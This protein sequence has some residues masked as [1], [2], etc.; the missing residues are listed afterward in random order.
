[1][2]EFR[3]TGIG[4]R[5]GQQQA[6]T[7][8]VPSQA[9]TFPQPGEVVVPARKA[10]RYAANCVTCGGRVQA[11]EGYLAGQKGAWAAEH[12]VCPTSESLAAVEEPTEPVVAPVVQTVVNGS[13]VFDGTYTLETLT[14]HRTFRLRTQARGEDFM[15]GKQIIEYLSGADNDADYTRFGHVAN[16]EVKVWKKHQGNAT[17]LADLQAFWADPSQALAAVQCYRCHRTLTVP[18]SVYNGLGP[19]CSKMGL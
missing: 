14:G 11:E 13:V 10:N 15:P 17:L 9:H 3:R 12:I 19:E 2:V 5:S 1:M 18:S 4:S 16:N 8:V 6:P 7:E